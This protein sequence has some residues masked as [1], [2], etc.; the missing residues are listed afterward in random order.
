MKI[1]KSQR[2]AD[3]IKQ[4][5]IN[6]TKI[7]Y[8]E[9]KIDPIILC[10]KLHRLEK[11]GEQLALDMCNVGMDENIWENKKEKILNKVD[12]LLNFSKLGVPVFFNGD[13]RGYALKIE[14][15]YVHEQGLNIHRDFG[16]YGILC[17]EY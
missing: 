1:S 2:R 17:P 7:F 12:N 15:E 3:Q 10:K 6:L 9:N 14:S 11:Q 5:G 13:P 8:L 16:G 4:H